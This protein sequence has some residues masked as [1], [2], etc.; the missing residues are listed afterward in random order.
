MVVVST[1]FVGISIYAQT[2]D[3]ELTT[4]EEE[5]IAAG[6]EFEDTMDLDNATSDDV[7]ND[8]ETASTDD[9][10]PTTSADCLTMTSGDNETSTSSNP[11]DATNVTSTASST[12]LTDNATSAANATGIDNATSTEPPDTFNATSTAACEVM[13]TLTPVE[14]SV[15]G[16]VLVNASGLAENSTLIVEAGDLVAGYP[17]SDEDGNLLYALGTS[18]EMSGSVTVTVEDEDGNIGSATL[19][20]IESQEEQAGPE[21]AP[22]TTNTTQSTNNLTTTE[23]SLTAPNTNDTT[24]AQSSGSSASPNQNSTSNNYT[25]QY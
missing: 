15:G 23:N 14:Q 5:A 24:T 17:E 8:T 11:M 13:V 16:T 6:E 20:I 19:T 2:D 4:F 1:A 3:S 10:T 22:S 12:E 9:G 18:D 25:P 21:N 7:A